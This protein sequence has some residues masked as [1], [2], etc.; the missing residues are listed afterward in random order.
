VVVY[1]VSVALIVLTII[2]NNLN[3]MDVTLTTLLKMLS[4]LLP[5]ELFFDCSCK[6]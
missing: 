2:C 6:I 5:S 4:M 3:V 1:K